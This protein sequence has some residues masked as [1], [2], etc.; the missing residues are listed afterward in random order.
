MSQT[1]C[2]YEVSPKDGAKCS[3]CKHVFNFCEKNDGV[4]SSTTASGSE[5]HGVFENVTIWNST[6]IFFIMSDA[7]ELQMVFQKNFT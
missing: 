2:F 7:E 6:R 3:F 5:L 1:G 4:V